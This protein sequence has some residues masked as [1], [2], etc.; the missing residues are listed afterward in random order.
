MTIVLP[1]RTSSLA[2]DGV[3]S[4]MGPDAVTFLVLRMCVEVTP[5]SSNGNH[6][7]FIFLMHLV[8]VMRNVVC[9]HNEDD[10]AALS[11]H[12]LEQ[13]QGMKKVGSATSW[14][15]GAMRV[16]RTTL[17]VRPCITVRYWLLSCLR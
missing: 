12:L 9:M 4:P 15:P 7:P 1:L 16:S 14:L 11:A 5:P 8:M 10:T 17:D 13:V 2:A 6:L 3:P